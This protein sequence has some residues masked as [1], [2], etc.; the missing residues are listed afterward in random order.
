MIQIFTITRISITIIQVIRVLVSLKYFIETPHLTW[1]EALIMFKIF[2]QVQCL[3]TLQLKITEVCSKT[4]HTTTME[5]FR[6]WFIAHP[7]ISNCLLHPQ[8][9]KHLSHHYLQFLLNRCILLLRSILDIRYK[10]KIP[11]HLV[12]LAAVV[13]KMNMCNLHQEEKVMR[14]RFLR[15]HQW[16]NQATSQVNSHNPKMIL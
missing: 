6:E 1:I 11:I 14:M 10:R 12:H 5:D 7:L 15:L 2:H 9:N 4:C 13:E 8:N 16:N 3:I